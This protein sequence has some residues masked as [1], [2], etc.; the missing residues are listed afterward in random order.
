MDITTAEWTTQL[1]K[2]L[3]PIILCPNVDFWFF[4]SFIDKEFIKNKKKNKLFHVGITI[5]ISRF[6]HMKK[7][8]TF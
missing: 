4:I 8:F 5:W 1:Q 6:V 2:N 3:C 7:L